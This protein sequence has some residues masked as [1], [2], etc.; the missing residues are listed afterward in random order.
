MTSCHSGSGLARGSSFRA[1]ERRSALHPK[2]GLGT[3]G[4]CTGPG[5]QGRRTPRNRPE[6]E[7]PPPPPGT[8][9]ALRTACPP[10]LTAAGPEEPAPGELFAPWRFHGGRSRAPDPAKAVGGS[11]WG[12]ML[13]RKQH[14]CPGLW[15]CQGGARN[16]LGFALGTPTR[17]QTTGTGGGGRLE[18]CDEKASEAKSGL[19]LQS[20][21]LR[22][23]GSIN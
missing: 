10:P 18:H 6:E 22:S 1:G 23:Y 8:G 17:F 16:D 2:G 5:R 11:D 4:A 19:R 12:D 15:C 7:Y 21:L 9:P 14:V 3:S 13:L 20:F